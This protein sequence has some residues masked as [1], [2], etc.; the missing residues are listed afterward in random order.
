MTILNRF[1]LSLAIL[2]MLVALN[3]CS[4]SES[5]KSSSKSSSASSESS[6][7]IVSS[8]FTSSSES[9]KSEDDYQDE[10]MDYTSAY[11]RS[12]D[13]DITS[14]RSGLSEIAAKNGVVNWEE[15]RDTYI[16]IGKGLKKANLTGIEY[17]TYKK[18]LAG[19]D[20]GKMEDIQKGYDSE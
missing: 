18:N 9:S 1:F 17:E 5:S 11:A 3:G 16:A 6:S 8:P 14:Y 4:F 12:S 19:S 20:L 7:K 10:V 2:A 15:D 13:G